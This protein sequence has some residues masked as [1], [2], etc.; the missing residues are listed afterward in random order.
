VICHRLLLLSQ[1]KTDQF[2]TSVVPYRFDRDY[3]FLNWDEWVEILSIAFGWLDRQKY[4]VDRFDCLLP[5]TPLV[6]R[7]N[8]KVFISEVVELP[9]YPL[10]LE[11]L[12]IDPESGNTQW[13]K[14]NW[15]KSKK[16]NK[17]IYTFN[18][19]EGLLQITEDHRLYSGGWKEASFFDENEAPLANSD[20]SCFANNG[21]LDK[22]LAYAYGLFLAEG[23]TSVRKTKT[24]NFSWQWH[25]DMR[26]RQS[27]ERAQKALERHYGIKLK[28]VLYPSQRKGSIRGGIVARND[29][30]RLKINGHYGDGR[31]LT[32]IFRPLFYNQRG[33]KIV[34]LEVLNANLEAKRAFLK[35]FLDGD[36]SFRKRKNSCSYSAPV[37]SPTAVLGLQIIAAH[38]GW[39]FSMCYARRKDCPI[40]LFYPDRKRIKKINVHKII[41]VNA[42]QTEV[43]DIN[44]ESHHFLAGAYLAHN[45]DNF[46]FLFSAFSALALQVN[47]AGVA[48][49][50][51][52]YTNG[53]RIGGHLW[54]AIVAHANQEELRLYWVEP[55]NLRW[56]EHI[57]GQ[58]RFEL[59]HRLYEPTWL[60]FF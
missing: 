33:Y 14:V 46:A 19:P 45:C 31:K 24:T 37:K 44:T 36:G 34:P 49:G 43:Y 59:G 28:I 35:G 12:D 6:C 48:R 17:P 50:E 40:V 51:Y 5:T 22:E 42:A 13:T 60:Q 21:E 3:W 53:K 18:R 25:I 23:H 16:T 10:G 4:K 52:Y 8:G 55:Q 1:S 27:L 15:V 54:N 41:V 56:K 47:T 39:G 29:M 9:E 2:G 20:W 32:E 58:K 57:K 7:Q 38:L 26:Q 30:Y 11:V